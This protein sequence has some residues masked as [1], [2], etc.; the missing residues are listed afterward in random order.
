M[1]DALIEGWVIEAVEAAAHRSSVGSVA[2]VTLTWTPVVWERKWHELGAL[3][4]YVWMTIDILCVARH[5]AILLCLSELLKPSLSTT[6]PHRLWFVMFKL[7]KLVMVTTG[8]FSSAC[9]SQ[10][11]WLSLS[12]VPFQGWKLLYQPLRL[13]RPVVAHLR[14][15]LLCFRLAFW[16]ENWAFTRFFVLNCQDHLPHLRDRYVSSFNNYLTGRLHCISWVEIIGMTLLQ[17]G[18]SFEALLF[19]QKR[20]YLIYFVR[21]VRLCCCSR[22]L[23]LT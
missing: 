4:P 5:I 23:A 15:S 12:W 14:W 7:F 13:L 11:E 2:T 8:F 1:I 16:S 17:S 6:C 20:N 3:F 21:L 19:F 9:A 18:L 10:V 22:I